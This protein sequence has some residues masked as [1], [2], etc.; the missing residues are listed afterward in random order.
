MNLSARR[1][2][3]GYPPR[4]SPLSTHGRAPSMPRSLQFRVRLPRSIAQLFISTLTHRRRHCAIR[5]PVRAS[6]ESSLVPSLRRT[7]LRVAAA[8][9]GAAALSTSHREGRCTRPLLSVHSSSRRDGLHATLDSNIARLAADCKLQPSSSGGLM[10]LTTILIIVLVVALL[11]G[12]GWYW[13]R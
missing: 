8:P 13:R 7:T 9:N 1:A 5:Q 6:S 2:G 3:D 11:F 12:G 4:K 10:S